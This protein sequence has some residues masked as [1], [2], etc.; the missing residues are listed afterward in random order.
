MKAGV[1][2][3]LLIGCAGAAGSLSRYFL[4]GI[5]HRTVGAD[6]PWGTAVVN[7]AGCFFFGL[8]WTLAEERL[9]ISSQMR[10]VILTGFMGAF[11]TFSTFIFETGEQLR[12]SQCQA[13]VANVVLQMAAG[14]AMLW[15]GFALGRRLF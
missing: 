5:V 14:L 9:L 3:L 1:T 11:T 7:I 10:I 15:A 6:F 4:T 13:A 8:V 12:H 2:E